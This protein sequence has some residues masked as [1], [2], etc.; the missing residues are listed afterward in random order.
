MAPDQNRDDGMQGKL[1][2][3]ID[4]R[5]RLLSPRPLVPVV[6]RLVARLKR[7]PP[8]APRPPTRRP[9]RLAK[10]S[11]ARLYPASLRETRANCASR[12]PFWRS[13]PDH[14]PDPRRHADQEKYNQKRRIGVERAV[15]N[16]ADPQADDDRRDELAAGPQAKRHRRAGG[17]RVR[18]GRRA[19]LGRGGGAA[20]PF[21]SPDSR[22]SRARSAADSSS[23]SPGSELMGPSPPWNE[24]RGAPPC[25]NA[26]RLAS[27]CL[28]SKRK[29][30]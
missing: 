22:L 21:S 8:A 11:A 25:F 10:P 14:V 5:S 27:P 3:R 7:A 1:V 29:R 2:D 6:V 17:A 15:E 16:P 4:R 12:R 19:W 23:G 26:P 18:F 24:T 13:Q 30:R 9:V 20:R 28:A